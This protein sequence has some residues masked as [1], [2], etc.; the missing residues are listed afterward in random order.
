M[1]PQQLSPKIVGMGEKGGEA[2]AELR[3]RNYNN[4]TNI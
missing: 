3:S 4:K 2:E 1:T